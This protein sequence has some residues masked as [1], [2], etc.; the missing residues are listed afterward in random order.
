[1]RQTAGVTI[2][3]A[4]GAGSTGAAARQLLGFEAADDVLAI[5]DR[6]GDVDRVVDAIGQAV[7][8]VH[9]CSRLIG[10]SLGAH[11]AIRWASGRADAPPVVCVLPAW[12]GL[13]PAGSSPTAISAQQ[14]E[15]MGI[16]SVLE[17][18][19]REE[20]RADITRLLAAGWTAY[21]DD[22]L[23][24]CLRRAASG[25]GPLARE[26]AGIRT[27]ATIVG[28][29]ADA[30]HPAATAIDWSRRIPRARITLAA[31]PRTSLLRQA[32]MATT[33]PDQARWAG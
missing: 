25:A 19:S 13:P 16:A 12:T 4:H 1:M 33:W 23:C 5:E 2:V 20:G 32:M 6:T 7:A 26:L 8:S 15:T 3:L 28:W 31:S 18:L 10:V 9:H 30:I 29:Y 21:T 14:I 22:D 17:H 24:A 11:A 27:P